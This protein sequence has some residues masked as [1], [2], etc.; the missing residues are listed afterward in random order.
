MET[1][2]SSEMTSLDFLYDKIKNRKLLYS[3]KIFKTMCVRKIESG[4]NPRIGQFRS[5]I[6]EL[7]AHVCRDVKL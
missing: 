1:K 6:F 5:R 3:D 7:P 2:N 4:F